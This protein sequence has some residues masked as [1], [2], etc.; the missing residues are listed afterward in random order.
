MGNVSDK[1][2]R[3]N[4]NTHFR[5]SKFFFFNCAIYEIMWKNIV[6]P[7]RPQMTIWCMHVASWIT[8]ATNTIMIYNT[9]CF[10]TATVVARTHLSV[11][12]YVNC[13][14][15]FSNSVSFCNITSVID[16]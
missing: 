15:F 1:S 10:S 5:F 11:M 7:D 3:E 13:L 8:K 9:Y 14:S 16:E 12:L 2:Y 6:E 4:R